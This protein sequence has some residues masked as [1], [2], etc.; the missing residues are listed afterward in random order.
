MFCGKYLLQH[1][2]SVTQH[3]EQP[4]KE[5]SMT[6]LFRLDASIRAEGSISREVADSVQRPWLAEHPDAR[7]VHRDLGLEPIPLDSWISANAARSTPEPEQTPQQQ[8]AVALAATLRDELLAADAYLFAVPLYNFGVPSNLKTWVD[9]LLT[10][11]EMGSG[12]PAPLAGRPAVLVVSRGGGY[13]AGTPREGW[14][15][16]TPWLQR[17][18]ADVLKLELRTVTAELTL[19]NVVPAMAG[20]KDLAAQSLTDAHLAAD[21]HGRELARAAARTAA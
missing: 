16:S 14:D 19:A 6:T 8:Q 9:V 7:I 2:P 21:Q 13:S 20:L 5:P 17:I 10:L 4:F 1:G 18:F 11:P 15:H 3:S 12:G